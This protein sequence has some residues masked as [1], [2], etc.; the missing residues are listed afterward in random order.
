MTG[1]VV[2]DPLFSG[3]NVLM[4]QNLMIYLSDTGMYTLCM[5]RDITSKFW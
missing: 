5:L 1:V 3:K 2:A 4:L